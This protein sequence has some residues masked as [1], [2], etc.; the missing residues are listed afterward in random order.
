LAAYTKHKLL[1][2]EKYA[3]FAPPP[4]SIPPSVGHYREW[5]EACKGNG[6]TTCHFGYAGPLAET[7][8]LGNVAYRSG[9]AIEWDAAQMKIPNAPQAERFLRR[10]YRGEWGKVIDGA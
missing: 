9:S 4:R 8:L 3:G 6:T 5:V 10:E 1:P 2:E 7:V